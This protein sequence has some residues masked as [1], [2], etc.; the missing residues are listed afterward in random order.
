LITTRIRLDGG[1]DLNILHRPLLTFILFKICCMWSC[2][3]TSITLFTR[4]SFTSRPKGYL[5]IWI[6]PHNFWKELY[7]TTSSCFFLIISYTRSPLMF[8]SSIP[9]LRC[10]ENIYIWYLVLSSI[11]LTPGMNSDI[12]DGWTIPVLLVASITLL[13]F[14]ILW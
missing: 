8:M 5:S 1:F 9:A 12:L 11:Y 4:H 10:T 3:I 13:L 2:A 6:V 7:T 14:K